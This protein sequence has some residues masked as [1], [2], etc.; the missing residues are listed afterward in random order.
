MAKTTI[1][2]QLSKQ[3]PA[4][5]QFCEVTYKGIAYTRAADNSGN[6][7]YEFTATI[8]WPHSAIEN[9]NFNPIALF[10]LYK[11]R[12]VPGANSASAI[13]N[14][15]LV[16]VKG[17]LP[18]GLPLEHELL[19]TTDRDRMLEI[20]KN[21]GKRPYIHTDLKADKQTQQ[22]VELQPELYPDADSL[23]KAL[24]RLLRAPEAFVKEQERLSTR[25][26]NQP[27]SMEAEI[28][29]LAANDKLS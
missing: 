11:W 14:L 9:T 5:P 21:L 6:E 28:L 10:K 8:P 27:R 15:W 16:D 1:E 7:K 3:A 2:E 13:R 12:L 18:K 4:V 26:E 20:A 19:W 22:W 23:R 29:A 17:E 24:L 25:F